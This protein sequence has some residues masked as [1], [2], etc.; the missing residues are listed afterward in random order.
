MKKLLVVLVV[1]IILV[2]GHNPTMNF[3][4]LDYFSG[5]YVVYTENFTDEDAVN[6]G[7]CYMNTKPQIS[8]IVGESIMV[9]NLEVSTAIDVLK[10]RVVKTEYL[11]DGTT[12]IYAY[13][14]LISQYVKLQNQKINLQLA[15]KNEKT[16]IGWPLILGSF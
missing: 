14:N 4:L 8:N 6:L 2:V 9:E 11:E 5:E 13:T 12:I 1:L 3:C 10:A 15:I 7:F 16:I